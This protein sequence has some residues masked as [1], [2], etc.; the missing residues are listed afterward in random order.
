MATMDHRHSLIREVATFIGVILSAAGILYLTLFVGFWALGAIANQSNTTIGISTDVEYAP[1]SAGAEV[2][3]FLQ[4][5]SERFGLDPETTD[6]WANVST[7]P[8]VERISCFVV[9]VGVDGAPP[10][11]YL[12]ELEDDSGSWRVSALGRSSGSSWV[13]TGGLT[14]P[15]ACADLLRD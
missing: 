12:V 1:G 9:D 14:E 10:A 3:R 6:F 11:S 13:A 4:T 15:A 7:A 5:E 8:A 2:V